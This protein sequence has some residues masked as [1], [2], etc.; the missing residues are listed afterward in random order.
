MSDEQVQVNGADTAAVEARA[1]EMGWIPREEFKGNVEHFVDAEA[2]VKRGE[3]LMPILRA[4]N[5]KLTNEL[6]STKDQLTEAQQLLRANMEAIEELKVFNATISKERV[7][8]RKRELTSAIKEARD[9][10]D[11]E[12]EMALTSEMTQLD[13]PPPV[14]K[15]PSSEKT[16]REEPSAEE[17]EVQARQT[18]EWK[19]WASTNTW[20]G[21]DQAKTDYA[22]FIGVQL[23]KRG[24]RDAGRTF[25]DAVSAEVNKAF[26]PPPNP[27]D[28][29]SRVEGAR[30]GNGASGNGRSYADLPAEARAACDRQASRL[31]G[32][33]RAFKD[34]AS[35]RKHYVNKYQWE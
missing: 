15:G 31:V 8:E 29:T 20:Y 14:E 9:A 33:G 30:G 4:N 32:P 10:G 21:T 26:P 11:I 6:H 24:N 7:V 34:E 16:S 3:E 23:R 12:Q 25:L 13:T 28:G 17:R 27:R 5:R 22:E 35:W 1:K 19:S 18:P 2:Y